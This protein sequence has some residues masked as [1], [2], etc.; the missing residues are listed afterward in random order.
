MYNT[1][2]ESSPPLLYHATNDD[3][4]G[5]DHGQDLGSLYRQSPECQAVTAMLE[6]IVDDISRI[7]LN[8]SGHMVGCAVDSYAT[9]VL[10]QVINI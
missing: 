4:L 3:G 10:W 2:A 7:E 1:V 9:N 8:N 5:E 6:P